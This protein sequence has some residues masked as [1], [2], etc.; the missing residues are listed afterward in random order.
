[1]SDEV[2]DDV[3]YK[4]CNY[5]HLLSTNEFLDTETV[6]CQ[7]GA[8]NCRLFSDSETIGHWAP[9]ALPRLHRHGVYKHV[10]HEADDVRRH[11]TFVRRDEQGLRI[12]TMR[13]T[14]R[15]LSCSK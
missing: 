11:C 2:F 7:D 10:M 5:N 1:M 3:A 12:L 8:S 4:A 14:A 13:Y 15:H 9:Q 6:L